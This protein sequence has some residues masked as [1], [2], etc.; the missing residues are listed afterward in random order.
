VAFGPLFLGLLLLGWL[1]LGI[2]GWL[3]VT[4]P[5]RQT[6]RFLTLLAALG[7]ALI[8]GIAPALMGWRTLAALLFSLPLA[9]GLA[10]VAAWGTAQQ[11][12]ARSA[13]RDQPPATGEQP[14]KLRQTG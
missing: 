9:L 3:V 7:A 4:V 11:L 10:A 13:R 2:L 12:G 6:P 1:G 8:G 14:K 5:L